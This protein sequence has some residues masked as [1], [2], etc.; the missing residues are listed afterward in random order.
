MCVISVGELSWIWKQISII[1]TSNKLKQLRNMKKISFFLNCAASAMFAIALTACNATDDNPTGF[2]PSLKDVT[3]QSG[4][5]LAPIYEKLAATTNDIII[6][7]PAGVDTVYTGEIEVIEGMTLTIV[8][9]GAVNPVIVSTKAISTAGNVVLKDVVVDGANTEEPI[10][11]LADGV[12][13]KSIIDEISFTNVTVNN[14]KN[15]LFYANKKKALINNLIVEN[16]IIAVKGANQKTMFDFNGGGLARLFTINKS[17]LSSDITTVWQNGGFYSTQSGSR[18]D[19]FDNLEAV[20]VSISNS[21]LDSICNARTVSTL[22][23]NSQQQQFYIVT[24]CI[25]SDCGKS[26][27]FLKGLNSGQ[28]GKDYNWFVDN[29]VF[30]S[31]GAIVAEQKIGSKDENIQN[32]VTITPDFRDRNNKN[33][34]PTNLQF[35]NLKYIPGDPR[36]TKWVY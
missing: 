26:G 18:I 6:E 17:T 12:A 20:V 3:I 10:V 19:D 22:R 33:F 1:K 25:I 21:T 31:N 11:Q 30:M 13:E 34:R 16:S 36:W 14:L 7:I 4:D 35:L 23:Q 24:N 8:G 27:Q 32:S 5:T 2:D 9:D 29:N 15:Q 28:A